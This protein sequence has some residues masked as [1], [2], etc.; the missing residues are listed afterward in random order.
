MEC[1]TNRLGRIGWQSYPWS[2]QFDFIRFKIVFTV[3]RELRRHKV[4]QVNRMVFNLG[5]QTLNAA[6]S[7]KPKEHARQLEYFFERCVR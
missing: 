6:N 1:Q 7:A 2:T 3:S 5:K 4:T